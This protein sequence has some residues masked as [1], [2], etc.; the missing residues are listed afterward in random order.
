M[1]PEIR[2]LMVATACRII[3]ANNVWRTKV[4]SYSVNLVNTGSFKA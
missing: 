4:V 3:E 1:P 2:I